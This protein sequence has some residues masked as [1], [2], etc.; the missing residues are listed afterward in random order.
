MA[1]R[2]REKSRARR[3]NK[4]DMQNDV[5]ISRVLR[6]PMALPVP[7]IP[8]KLEKPTQQPTANPNGHLRKI[9]PS[10]MI[11]NANLHDFDPLAGSGDK[12]TAELAGKPPALQIRLGWAGFM[13]GEGRSTLA[14][15]AAGHGRQLEFTIGG[16]GHC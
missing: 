1:R 4:K 8:I 5:F 7:H 3:L 14:D 12:I 9:R 6:M 15:P 16:G 10:R 13:D 2:P 11:P